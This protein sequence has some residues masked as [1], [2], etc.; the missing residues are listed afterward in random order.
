LREAVELRE[1]LKSIKLKSIIA[2]EAINLR[3]ARSRPIIPRKA[4]TL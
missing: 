3:E 4:I 1:I 2:R